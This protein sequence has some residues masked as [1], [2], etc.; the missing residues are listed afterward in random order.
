MNLTK[1]FG[2]RAILPSQSIDAVN[3]S[4][5]SVHATDAYMS[6]AAESRVEVRFKA[7]ATREKLQLVLMSKCSR[8]AQDLFGQNTRSGYDPN[9]HRPKLSIFFLSDLQGPQVGHDDL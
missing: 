3:F 6:F 8:L 1:I 4:I 2:A 9:V 5:I 7:R